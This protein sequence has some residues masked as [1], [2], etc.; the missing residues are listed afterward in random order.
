MSGDRRKEIMY[1]LPEEKIDELLRE[2]TDDR[3]KERVGFLKNLYYGD[4]VTKLLTARDGRQQPGG[5]GQTPG[6]KVGLT[7]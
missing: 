1:H 5:A 3:R 7:D 6:M 4:S 2:T